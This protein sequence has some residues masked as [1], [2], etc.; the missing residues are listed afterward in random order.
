MALH[1]PLLQPLQDLA[2]SYPPDRQ[3]SGPILTPELTDKLSSIWDSYSN[4]PEL[5]DGL[6]KNPDIVRS[7][8]ELI[9]RESVVLA[10]ING[11]LPEPSEDAS[12]EDKDVFQ[13]A[14]QDR[15]DMIL[16]L[17]EVAFIANQESPSLEPGALFIPLLE[18]LVELLSITTWRRL[19]SYIETRSKRYTKGMLPSRGK[20][21][22]LLRTINAFLRFLP[23]T[24]SDLVFRGRIHQFASSVFSV[25][26]KSAINMRGDYGEVKTVWEEEEAPSE[27]IKVDE[28][29]KEETEEKGDVDMEDAEEKQPLT[30]AAPPEADFYSTLWS[31]QQYFAHP[32]SLD[33]PPVG[34]PPQTPF[35]TFRQKSG[36]VLPRLFEET[37]KE[38]ELSG[39]DETVG[40]KRKREDGG[41]FHPRYLTGKRLFSYELLDPSFRRQILVQYLILFQFLLNLTPAHAGKQA[42]TG[43]M[44]RSFVLEKADEE[45]VTAKIK[46]IRGEMKKMSGGAGF[47]DTI[48]SIIRQEAHY[49]S[50]KNDGCPESAF[51]IPPLDASSSAKSASEDWSRGLN[52]PYPYSFKVGSRSLSMLWN[53]GF[54]SIDQLKGKAPATTVEGLD[55]LIR[56]MEEDEE[57]DKA[58]GQV[59]PEQL[60]A[61]KE[62]KTTAN[63]RAL[64][65]A[66]QTSLKHFP[67]LKHQRSIHLLLET[68]KQ[69][70]EPKAQAPKDGEGEVK[71]G[72]SE[73]KE[74]EEE[75]KEIEGQETVGDEKEGEAEG[76]EAKDEE[77]KDE[78]GPKDEDKADEGQAPAEPPVEKE[79]V[80]EDKPEEMRETTVDSAVTTAGGEEQTTAQIEEPEAQG[81]EQGYLDAK[82]ESLQT[83]D[84]VMDQA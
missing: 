34:S 44:P 27:D 58:M 14:L 2:A 9:G 82:E 49:A 60:A 67:A 59:D 76:E 80:G 42:F 11:Q 72:E 35:Q 18:E 39:K 31:L 65:L 5:P 79:E 47:E 30:P 24:P 63:W 78:E 75:Q 10:V 61:N 16:T 83:G 53:N 20:S 1:Q 38:K 48:F 12:E 68:I 56:K 7:V 77:V 26:D 13:V 45:W 51:E 25:A 73:E 6:A 21:L 23:R 66:S 81:E 3:D 22:P 69:S 41:F 28:E 52:A 40:K 55:E 62:R 64:R 4:S 70:Q 46:E 43:G 37:Q 57:D 36:L 32:P 29:V 8:L 19:W 71:V 84:V 50:W 54:K 17:Y 74:G 15:L 33:G